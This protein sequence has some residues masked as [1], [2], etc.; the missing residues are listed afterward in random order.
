MRAMAAN[1]NEI[2]ARFLVASIP[3]SLENI[4]DPSG[5]T[6]PGFSSKY[7]ALWPAY[8]KWT[9]PCSTMNTPKMIFIWEFLLS[10]TD[11]SKDLLIASS[12]RISQ[13]PFHYTC[14]LSFLEKILL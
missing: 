11:W 13:S 9:R 10:K 1:S 3:S 12:I 6:I 2:L 4:H 7:F 5:Q 14:R 8:N